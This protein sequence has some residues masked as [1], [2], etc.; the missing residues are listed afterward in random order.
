VIDTGC[1]TQHPALASKIW[2]NPGESGPDRNGNPKETNAIDDDGNG[3][4]DDVAGWNFADHSPDVSDDHGHGTHVAGIIAA[5]L[6][7]T[8]LGSRGVD[9]NVSLMILKYYDPTTG[10]DNL[11]NTIAAIHYA[12]KM[13]ANIINYSGGGESRSREEEQAIRDARDHHVLVVAAAGNRGINTDYHHY[14]PADYELENILSVTGI[15]RQNRIMGTS[16][17]GIRT[18][19]IAAPGNNIYST[20]PN[21]MY[22]Y[23]TGTSQATAF[24]TGVAALLMAEEARLRKPEALI[25]HL[26]ET[27]AFRRE[28]QGRI[29][30]GL[31]DA[32]AATESLNLSKLAN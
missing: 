23:M 3:F 11:K 9:P 14:Y 26:L 4:V 22:G 5:D 1:D 25:K 10:E 32:R 18:V 31:L 29:R 21:G 30:S 19:S 12:V 8:E 24:A 27:S 16:N 15:D 7:D 2:Q 20:L 17:Y 13:G 28:L 6:V